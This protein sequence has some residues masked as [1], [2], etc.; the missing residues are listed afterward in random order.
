MFERITKKLKKNRGYVLI[1][2]AIALPI[3]FWGVNYLV[4]RD[5]LSHDEAIKTAAAGA[6]GSAVLETYKP[7]TK[8]DAQK[9][10]VYAAAAQALNDKAYSLSHKMLV[11]PKNQKDSNLS[12]TYTTE[13]IICKCPC[14]ERMATVYN[15]KCNVDI[16]LTIPTNHAANTTKNTNADALIDASS[17]SASSTPIKIVATAY[18]DFLQNNF[19]HI[20]GVAVGLV[21]YSAKITVPSNRS[22]WTITIQNLLTQDATR[23]RQAYVYSSDGQLGGQILNSGYS[24]GS[25]NNNYGIMSRYGTDGM[26]T[27]GVEVLSTD[28]PTQNKDKFRRMNLNP[29]YL[30]YCNLLAGACEKECTTYQ[31]NPYPII[32]LTDDVSSVIDKLN[33]FK[34]INDTKNK[35]NFLFLPVLWARNLLSD[36]TSH[37]SDNNASHPKR[38]DKKKVVILLVNAPDNFAPGELTYLGFANDAAE[39]SM[40]ESDV[41]DFNHKM[42]QGTKGIINYSGKGS[43]SEENKQFICDTGDGTLSFPKKGLVKVVVKPA[44]AWQKVTINGT[45]GVGAGDNAGRICLS[46]NNP[47]FVN[48]HGTCNKLTLEK[49]GDIPTNWTSTTEETLTSRLSAYSTDKF[50]LG[51]RCLSTNNYVTIGTSSSGV[52]A[53]NSTDASATTV[54]SKIPR[55]SYVNL[56]PRQSPSI[57]FANKKVMLFAPSGGYYCC[58][59][60]DNGKTWTCQGRTGSYPGVLGFGNKRWIAGQESIYYSTDNG[61]TWTLCDNT[62]GNIYVKPDSLSSGWYGGEY[63]NNK[64][65][66]VN[67]NGKVAT[68]SNGSNWLEVQ[69]LPASA[70]CRNITLYDK[71]LWCFSADGKRSYFI[72][73]KYLTSSSIKFSNVNNNSTYGVKNNVTCN[74]SEQLTFY[75]EPSQIEDSKDKNGNYYISLNMTNICLV[76]AEITNRPCSL[77]QSEVSYS[78]RVV[79][80]K[81]A[82]EPFEITV[83]PGI[84][85]SLTISDSKVGNNDT[86]SLTAGESKTFEFDYLNGYMDSYETYTANNKTKQRL[87]GTQAPYLKLSYACRN[88]NVSYSITDRR[89]RFQAGTNGHQWFDE[90][91]KHSVSTRV[92]EHGYRAGGE[93]VED[94]DSVVFS[95]GKRIFWSWGDY[96]TGKLKIYITSQGYQEV[97]ARNA[98]LEISIGEAEKNIKNANECFVELPKDRDLANGEVAVPG[99]EPTDIGVMAEQ[100]NEKYYKHN[101]VY[102]WLFEASGTQTVNPTGDS[103]NVSFVGAGKVKLKVQSTLSDTPTITLQ[104]ADGTEETKEINEETT[105]IIDPS[106]YKFEQEKKYDNDGFGYF[107]Y[108]VSLGLSGVEVK[109]KSLSQRKT[110]LCAL[111]SK[112]DAP[113]NCAHVDFSSTT[114]GIPTTNTSSITFTNSKVKWVETKKAWV[115]AAAANKTNASCKFTYTVASDPF[116]Q[117]DFDEISQWKLSTD[118]SAK[119]VG[120]L[121]RWFGTENSKSFTF[122]TTSPVANSPTFTYGG[123]ALLLNSILWAYGYQQS[124]EA[125]ATSLNDGL[126]ALT[127]EACTKFS[128]TENAIADEVYLIKYKNTSVN[129]LDACA[130]SKKIYAPTTL[131]KLKSNL[132]TIAAD[133]K[134]AAEYE[135]PRI[136]ISPLMP[137]SE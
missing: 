1:L 27:A 83:K 108:K 127:A 104:K 65:H 113:I 137:G 111:Y 109:D 44:G 100:T 39:I 107:E 62:L 133:I 58:T 85:S 120:S 5:K 56:L 125:E 134:K 20:N 74:V 32:E 115:A 57:L 96:L 33:N 72:D 131:S 102:N 23:L 136:V 60:D 34:P 13:G 24:W 15:A 46:G 87:K 3:F 45:T 118:S 97:P 128:Y 63:T 132:N 119:Y 99:W 22:T 76:S 70:K 50:N 64:F 106:T 88:A 47:I 38:P 89:I 98:Y 28:S 21:P 79:T 54:T 68:S 67:Y 129:A 37:P 93:Y 9:A 4:K 41:I 26:G 112:V 124:Q 130:N 42:T 91:L 8:W 126:G 114:G 81:Y 51:I 17:E 110:T 7:E 75:I 52:I 71:K 90:Q 14:I 43:Y 82:A 117:L 40:L 92:S 55:T 16:V 105:L 122:N 103:G 35:S 66:A 95:Y 6:V 18:S 19:T 69:S 59:S 31:S 73:P 84:T 30:G 2:V 135:E 53:F 25:G 121:W 123:Y 101:F 80:S 94:E 12:L 77:R 36:W 116:L 48:T 11:N 86:Y 29:C 49:D 78:N 10:T 61:K